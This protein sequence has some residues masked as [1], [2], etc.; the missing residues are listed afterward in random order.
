MMILLLLLLLGVIAGVLAGLLGIGGGILFTPI[1][2]ILFN[3]AGLE[4]PVLLA[5]ASSLFCTFIAALASSIRQYQQQ[6][7]YPVEG[8]RVGLLG[9][10]GVSVGKQV[11]TS[12][13]YS[14][15]EFIMV[16]SL[17][18]L[19]VS[20]VFFRRGSST[21]QTAAADESHRQE[22]PRADLPKAAV[23]GGAGGF[24]AALAGI[25]GGGVMVPIMNLYYGFPFRKAVSISSLAIVLI[26]LS[27]WLQLGFMSVDAGA[28][29]RYVWGYVDFGAALPLSVGGMAGGFLGALL[30][31]KVDRTYL[32]YGFALLAL[33]M[34][35]KL[36]SELI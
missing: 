35:A 9:A 2:F 12:S 34:A 6:N 16:F 17:V 10:I 30:N 4:N 21:D 23:T 5:I 33:A 14:E 32:Q 13:Y 18:L 24:I 27:G 29:T 31:L 36:I 8:L 1:L 11:V 15:T 28:L 22:T 19:Y 25:G 20:W 7:L 26:S 3:N